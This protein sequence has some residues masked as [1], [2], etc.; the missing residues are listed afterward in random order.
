MALQAAFRT[1]PIFEAR[2][3]VCLGLFDPGEGSVERNGDSDICAGWAYQ[4]HIDQCG[5]T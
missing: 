4:K 3:S 2:K 5:A 1:G